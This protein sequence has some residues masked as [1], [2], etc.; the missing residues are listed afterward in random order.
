MGS[1][2]IPPMYQL[3]LVLS[4]VFLEPVRFPRLIKG[5]WK[6]AS[7]YPTV[8]SIFGLSQ[9]TQTSSKLQIA[10]QKFGE[11]REIFDMV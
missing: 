9:C 10:C 1:F 7:T 4:D 11:V 6:P 2:Q 5:V 3:A 8:D